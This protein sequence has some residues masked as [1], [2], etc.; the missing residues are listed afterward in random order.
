MSFSIKRC[1]LLSKR[2][3]IKNSAMLGFE[4]RKETADLLQWRA[5][6]TWHRG[7]NIQMTWDGNEGCEWEKNNSN[8]STSLV[9]VF[10]HNLAKR[11]NS[12][13]ITISPTSINWGTASNE[14]APGITRTRRVSFRLPNLHK[15][16]QRA[17]RER[18]QTMQLARAI[19]L[20]PLTVT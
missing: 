8:E 18:Y 15:R 19:N 6:Q 9:V 17:P 14:Q 1:F 3:G 12:V 5:I 4:T 2:I 10:P 20:I 16:I 11:S 7:T 13:N